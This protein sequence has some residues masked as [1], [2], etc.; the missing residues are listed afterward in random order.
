MT[1]CI[2]C[3][4]CE[5]VCPRQLTKQSELGFVISD[6]SLCNDCQACAV[7][8][9]SNVK[10]LD[11][12]LPIADYAVRAMLK[13]RRSTKRFTNECITKEQFERVLSL[14]DYM[15]KNGNKIMH[16]FE[17]HKGQPII[18]LCAS[19]IE[20]ETIDGCYKN[21]KFMH[22]VISQYKNGIDTIGKNSPYVL[23]FI[24]QKANAWNKE[25]SGIAYTYLNFACMS[26]GLGAL[27]LG[28]MTRVADCLN[29][30]IGISDNESIY[31]IY[32]IGKP[33]FIPYGVPNRKRVKVDYKL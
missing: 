5:K 23:L 3:G 27:F 7:Y 10:N 28:Y 33:M 26:E 4:I 31:G 14:V 22:L 21:Y 32:G 20:K 11:L 17:V 19:A 1:N 8:C 13:Q 6:Y 12:T 30:Y 9:P 25:L 2:H 15:P 24:G 16:R 29:S 18:G